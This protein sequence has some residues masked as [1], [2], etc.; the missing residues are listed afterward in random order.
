MEAFFEFKKLQFFGFYEREMYSVTDSVDNKKVLN[1]VVE[2]NHSKGGAKV[3]C[4]SEDDFF[5][6][7]SVFNTSIVLNCFKI[8]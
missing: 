5:M 2:K 8:S 6:N 7:Y 3:R 4:D 1:W